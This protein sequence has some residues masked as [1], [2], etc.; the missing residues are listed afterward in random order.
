M[1]QPWNWCHNFDYWTH[2]VAQAR[3]SSSRLCSI[4]I[5]AKINLLKICYPRVFQF[6]VGGGFPQD[7]PSCAFRS[8][9]SWQLSFLR[10]FAVAR[11][12][13]WTLPKW[14]SFTS[15]GSS[16]CVF[17]SIA[18][19]FVHLKCF[20]A[21]LLTVL[22][23]IVRSS[24]FMPLSSLVPR[25]LPLRRTASDGKLGGGL[26][27]RLP[28]STLPKCLE[29]WRNLDF[30][31]MVTAS[32]VPRPFLYRRGEK[33]EGRKGLVNNSTPTRIHGISLMFN[34]C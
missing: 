31:T 8:S 28:L 34:N 30:T 4:W 22:D 17:S 11:T 18:S 5:A 24:H 3:P 19:T 15:A 13:K 29:Q 20:A 25:P 21:L 23:S 26:G 9:H 10:S 6:R 1:R 12:V 2:A 27:T 7:P 16:V 32:L 14:G 33:G